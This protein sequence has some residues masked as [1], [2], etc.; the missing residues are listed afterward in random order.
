VTSWQKWS[1]ANQAY[2]VHELS[3]LK[4]I[5]RGEEPGERAAFEE[6]G[7][8][9]IDTLSACFA[10]TGFERALLLLCA[11]VEMDSEVAALCARAGGGRPHASFG[12]ALATQPDAHWSALAPVRPLRRWR[13]IEVSEDVPLAS[14]PLRIDERV[15]HYLA[16]IDYLDPRLRPLL[17]EVP[18]AAIM[19]TAQQALAKEVAAALTETP[20][21]VVNMAGN[22]PDG[23]RDVASTAASLCGMQL[24]AMS[25]ADLPAGAHE[26]EALAALWERESALLE[27]ALLVECAV[28]PGALVTRFVERVGGLVV[29]AGTEHLNL[30]RNDVRFR[31]DKP[32]RQDQLVLWKSVLNEGSAGE[33]SGVVCEFELSA[34]Q[35]CRLGG[36]L[37]SE[38]PGEVSRQALWEACRGVKRIRLDGLAQ[39]IEPSAGWADLVLPKPQKHTLEQISSQVRNRMLV[40]DS[41]GFEGKSARGLGISALFSGESGTGKTMAAEVL[42]GEL[43]LDLYR[44]DLSGVVSKYIGE[45]EKNLSRIFEAAEGGGAILLF[46]EADALFGKRSE[47]KDSHDRYANI[48][49][50]YLLQRMESYRGL[51]ILTTNQK[52]ALDAAFQRRL[53]FVVHFPFPDLAE[54]AEIWR[55]VFPE[56]TPTEELAYD[57]LA[58]LQMAGGHV[59]NIALSAAFHAAENGRPVSMQHLLLAAH[60]EAA[61]TER[62]LTDAETRGWL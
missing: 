38:A 33:L 59:R 56:D 3:R 15:L 44:I 31:V 58:R 32:A 20:L 60:A 13:L 55:R 35:I 6:E 57:K 51:A 45:T 5:L 30:D 28:E 17:R 9:A 47:V 36:R 7:A 34:R 26:I 40:Y 12:L 29:V 18:E 19:A 2:L 53:R 61:R 24:H 10:L 27:S 16:G 46:D 4:A 43:H 14:A 42:A 21:P 8:A 62:G 39:R 11:G 23:K 25:E 41:W 22:D 54:R 52:A 37:G 49:V 48:E 50:S 1:D